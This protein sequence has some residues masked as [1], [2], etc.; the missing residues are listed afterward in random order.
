MTQP[1]FSHLRPQAW[2][3]ET[4]PL[5]QIAL[6]WGSQWSQ[7]SLHSVSIIQSS[8]GR[9]CLCMAKKS[10]KNMSKTIQFRESRS[11]MIGYWIWRDFNWSQKKHKTS[12][13]HGHL[14]TPRRKP[15]F[16]TNVPTLPKSEPE[17]TGLVSPIFPT[18][19]HDCAYH[20]V[21]L[22]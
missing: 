12:S 2:Y 15:G 4:A 13:H 18:C 7:G 9:N 5:S 8:N 16:L 19:D 1:C 21:V 17:P 10:V 22:G 6:S 20:Q 3:R 11:S 14:K